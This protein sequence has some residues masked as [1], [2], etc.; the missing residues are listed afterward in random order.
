MLVRLLIFNTLI[1]KELESKTEINIIEHRN[2]LE[3]NIHQLVDLNNHKR[4]KQIDINN[5]KN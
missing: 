2:L 1:L 3:A 5:Q 4:T